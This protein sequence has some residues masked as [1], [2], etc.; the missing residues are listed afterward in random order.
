[1]EEDKGSKKATGEQYV[2]REVAIEPTEKVFRKG[3]RDIIHTEHP[4]PL[5]Y[6]TS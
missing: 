5:A 6:L 1:M 3:K 2:E 4:S